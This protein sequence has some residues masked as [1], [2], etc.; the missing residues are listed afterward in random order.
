MPWRHVKN[1]TYC[2]CT[3]KR[4]SR[5]ALALQTAIMAARTSEQLNALLH[6]LERPATCAFRA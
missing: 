6:R 3:A 1:R 2:G 4:V 5:R